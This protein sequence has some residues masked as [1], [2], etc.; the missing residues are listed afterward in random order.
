MKISKRQLKRIIR[1]EKQ[2]LQELDF[3]GPAVGTDADVYGTP[4]QAEVLGSIETETLAVKVLDGGF[5]QIMEGINVGIIQFPISEIDELIDI[6][7]QVQE[8]NRQMR[9]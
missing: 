6:L 2:R 3:S 4:E 1:E 7:Y 9:R 8:D 5:V